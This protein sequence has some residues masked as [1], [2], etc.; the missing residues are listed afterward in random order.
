M[1][2]LL[3]GSLTALSLQAQA[4]TEIDGIEYELDA[5]TK[6]A[7]VTGSSGIT[8]LT[9]P[10]SVS[11]SGITY[12]VTSISERAFDSAI[13][14][15]SIPASITEIG[16]EAFT[17]CT[18]LKSV[19]FEDGDTPIKLGYTEP[20]YYTY[21][22]I[23]QKS[24]LETLYLGRNITYTYWDCDS[25]KHS[26]FANQPKLTSITIG[27]SVTELPNYLFYQNEAVTIMRL[28]AVR[29]IGKYCFSGCTKLSTLDLGTALETVG[30]GAFSDC[31]N[32]TNLRFPDTT[33]TLGD[34]AFQNC[35]SVTS[36]TFGTASQI[37]NIGDNAFNGCVALTAAKL[38]AGVK[39]LGASSF[40]GCKKLTYVSLG[41]SLSAISEAT[42]KDCVALS[43]MVVPEG[44]T[45]IGDQAFYNCEAIATYSLP[46]SLQTIGSEVFYNN[47]G[48]TSLQIPGAVTA[49]GQNCFYG[50]TRL[51]Y[52][53]FKDGVG[54]LKIDNLSTHT[55]Q[56]S[57]YYN[58]VAYDY[59]YD[60]PI[61][62]LYIGKDLEYQY[63]SSTRIY[64][65]DEN[66]NLTSIY[67]ESAPFAHKT[68]IR[69][70]NI[71]PK[72]TTLWDY[73]LVGCTEVK[74]LT[75]PEGLRTIKTYA[76]SGCTGLTELSFP[77][78]L[79]SL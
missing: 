48:F 45:S 38:P 18:S 7:T 24:P 4:A 17:A 31:S 6:I 47:G 78:S 30:D 62:V 34:G 60:C 39:V 43:E 65:Y 23:F 70:V 73:L 77:G 14:S 72:V 1:K 27:P 2:C 53:T 26:A 41:K 29:T 5:A 20:N 64:Y 55:N 69:T 57:A 75:F 3:L 54:T 56:I 71:G 37:E 36:L 10:S 11:D 25:K 46:E 12:S 8:G 16:N 67:R 50:C 13:T 49:M 15:I 28:H 42:F 33:T 22:G 40:E 76:F 63:N 52:L 19:R 35:G 32:L 51:M 44:V 9:I 66:R 61:R 59:F 58:S 68:T 79:T 21:G 74:K